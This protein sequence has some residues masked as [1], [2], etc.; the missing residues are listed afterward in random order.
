MCLAMPA[1]VIELRE[2]GEKA[3]VEQLGSSRE[4]FNNV[5]NAKKGDFVLLQQGFIVE[6][7][8]EKEAREA[9]KTLEPD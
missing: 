2:N 6:R 4:V 1:K 9:L 5:V 8:S 3:V 7:L